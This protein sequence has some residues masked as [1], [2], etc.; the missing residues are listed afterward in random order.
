[1]DNAMSTRAAILNV[2]GSWSLYLCEHVTPLHLL[3]PHKY[4]ELNQQC[5]PH[6]QVIV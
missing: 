3:I 4:E 1:M 2:I 6:Q 5:E